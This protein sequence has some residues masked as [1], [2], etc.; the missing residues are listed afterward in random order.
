[1]NV[2]DS[3]ADRQYMAGQHENIRP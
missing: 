3:Y 1:M 2:K